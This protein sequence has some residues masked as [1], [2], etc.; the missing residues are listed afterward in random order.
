VILVPGSRLDPPEI[1]MAPLIDCVFLLLVFFLL[2][3]TYA[4]RKGLKIELPGASTA[5]AADRGRIEVELAASGEM[6][7]GGERVEPGGLEA[8]LR[9]AAAGEGEACVF[10]MADRRACVE[11]LT[12]VTDAARKA[13]L[14]RL[15]IAAR[16]ADEGGSDER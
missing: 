12:R 16:T 10:V 5:E 4:S 1:G 7:V 8:A 9:R 6:R 13:G 3:T 14:A 11:S 2:T 15:V